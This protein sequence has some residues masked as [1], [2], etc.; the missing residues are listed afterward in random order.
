MT[1]AEVKEILRGQGMCGHITDGHACILERHHDDGAHD[2]GWRVARRNVRSAYKR[3][4]READD[5]VFDVIDRRSHKVFT[6]S[7]QQ[8]AEWLA[9]TLTR[10]DL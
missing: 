4:E 1:E 2:Q 9:S 6:T 7:R 8:D 10:L 5:V 3:D